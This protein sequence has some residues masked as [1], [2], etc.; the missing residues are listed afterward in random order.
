MWEASTLETIRYCWKKLKIWIHGGIHHVHGLEYSTLR[1][2]QLI[3]IDINSM[4]V[5]L[6]ISTLFGRIYN[7]ISN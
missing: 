6:E 7:L 4:Q 3:L 2:C 5:H 1:K